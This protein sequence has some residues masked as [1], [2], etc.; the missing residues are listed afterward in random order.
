MN[1][2]T[3]ISFFT[4]A[5][6]YLLLGLCTEL[7]A[8]DE[9]KVY[10]DLKLVESE[11]LQVYVLDLSNQQFD[12]FPTSVLSCI[13]LKKLIL[14]DTYLTSIPESIALLTNL[15]TF[16]F[17]HLEKPNV[18][19]KAL[20]YAMA[21]LKRL[22]NVGLI[23]LPNLNWNEAMKTLQGLPRLNN[24]ALMKN[25]F[26]TLPVGIEKLTS[27]QQIW[28][29]GNTALD[30]RDV[31]D[32]LPFLKQVGFGGSQYIALPDNAGQATRLFNIW[33]AGNKLTSVM[34]LLNNQNLKSISLNGNQLKELPTG[35]TSLSV[36]VLM[37]DNNP[38]LEWDKVLIELGAM[39]SVKQLSLSNNRLTKP[40][41]ALIN[42]LKLEVLYLVGNEFDE[43]DKERVRRLL[44]NAK[45]IF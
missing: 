17:N 36:E 11:P 26:K 35:L 19:F 45:I 12:K 8:Q 31:F 39:T 5:N 38:D 27:L 41:K 2:L 29:G 25:D 13:H 24:L 37:L 9:N 42:L 21:Q 22:E 10:K 18:E 6:I 28:L 43:G 20:P 15:E 44:P 30:P 40:P 7:N 32:K 4:L 3:S 16:E 1:N 23:G 14:S 33:L 34:P